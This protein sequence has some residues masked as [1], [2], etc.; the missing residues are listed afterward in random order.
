MGF[1]LQT[2]LIAAPVVIFSISVHEMFHAWVAD[3]R[4]D[5]TARRLG[6]ITLNPLAHFDFMGVLVLF[7]SKFQFGWG[8]PVPVNPFNLENPR[9]DDL[10]VAAAGPLS[11]IGLA[12]ISGMIFRLM[13]ANDL[14]GRMEVVDMLLFRMVF[15]NVFL[16]MFN[17]IPLFPLDGS[18]ILRGLL[19]EE[20]DPILDRIFQISPMILLFIIMSGFVLPVS[21][22]WLILGPFIRALV[23]LFTG[24]QI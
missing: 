5:P 2:I 1:D 8:K 24:Y 19:P 21:I 12:F 9:R 23:L 11:N 17:L 7:A 3:K 15:I 20:F 16:A 18:H 4:G 14:L 22:I 13:A 6:R 10:F